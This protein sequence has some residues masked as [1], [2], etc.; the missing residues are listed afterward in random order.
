MK[1]TGEKDTQK[2]FREVTGIPEPENLEV[3]PG[4]ISVKN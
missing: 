4:P 2:E 3:E 1:Q